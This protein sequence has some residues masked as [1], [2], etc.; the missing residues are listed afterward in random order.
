[1][2]YRTLVRSLVVVTFLI[3]GPACIAA[4]QPPAAA[5]RGGDA[6]VVLRH[7]FAKGQSSR[8][9]IRV[10]LDSHY[11]SPDG[12]RDFSLSYRASF[13]TVWAVRAV[14]ADGAA[15]IEL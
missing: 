14:R 11:P 4:E 12:T 15:E 10:D 9:A 13:E 2:S 5:A 6:P 1:M 3:A 7:T 8:Y